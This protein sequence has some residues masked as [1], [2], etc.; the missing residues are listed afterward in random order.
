[1]S[2]QVPSAA[3]LTIP[4]RAGEKHY[5]AIVGR[6]LIEKIGE[7]ASRLFRGRTCA[8][9]ADANTAKLF[10]TK[11]VDQLRAAKFEPTLITIPP[12]ENSKSLEQ[13]GNICEQM[14]V[15][16]LDRGSFVIALGGGV[17][18]DLAGFAAAIYHRGISYI[19]VP[20]TLLAQVD[21]SIGGK[22]G[23]NTASG[24]NLLGAVHQP[25]LVLVDV[26]TLQTLPP[27][28]FN[29]GFAEIIKHAI[30]ADPALFDMLD[31]RDMI[32]LVAHNIRIK[33]GIVG[34]DEND[35]LGHR[36]V[37]NF[38]H[39]V[40]HAI[41]RAIGYGA[42]LHGEAISLGIVAACEISVRRAGFKEAECEKVV[43]A[44][45][46]F[47]LPTKL[48]PNFPREKILSALKA[49]KKFERGEVRFVVTPHLGSARLTS[50]VTMSD[51]E[52]AVEKL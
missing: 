18:G 23:V 16:G 11:I 12:G 41:E 48:P 35:S 21:S 2:S 29:Q 39:T 52:A 31:R 46:A 9:V 15:A 6:G 33:A 14:S 34:R 32:E 44:L 47:D 5:D 37:L 42:L 13:A 10:A 3:P 7:H 19:Q 28:E 24:K 26:D 45:R 36:A 17:V 43:E 22:T 27:R 51:I 1:M 50:D 30:I 4:I 49:D 40:G 8:L 20:T 38:G 25:A